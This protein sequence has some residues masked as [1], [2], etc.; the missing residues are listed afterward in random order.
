ME[1]MTG[2]ADYAA[3]KKELDTELQKTA[4]GFVK[5]GYLLK[6]ARDTDILRE[7][8]YGN[9]NDFA[10]AEYGIDNTMVSKWIRINDRFSESGYSD[11][12]KEQYR[13]FG[14]A[15]LAI[16][17]QL[18]DLLNEELTPDYSKSEIQAIKNEVD[19]ERKITDMEVL[20][21]NGTD[22]NGSQNGM[23]DFTLFEKIL[24][25]ICRDMPHV[26]KELNRALM[27]LHTEP[28]AVKQPGRFHEIMAPAGDAVYSIRVQG[29]GKFMLFVKEENISVINIRSGEKEMHTFTELVEFVKKISVPGMA[30]EQ[31][32][33]AVYGEPFPE[34]E[35]KEIAPVQPEPPKGKKKRVMTAGKKEEQHRPE[36]V[37]E[38][39][40][41]VSGNVQEHGREEVPQEIPGNAVETVPEEAADGTPEDA[42]EDLPE[43]AGAMENVTGQSEIVE[44]AEYGEYETESELREA[45]YDLAKNKIA[46]LIDD[47]TDYAEMPL[48]KITVIRQNAEQLLGILK[49][50]ERRK[51]Q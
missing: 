24:Y 29:H 7:S 33:E 50:L 30:A 51:G 31:S 6:V 38:V 22:R 44:D 34:E 9:V 13:G 2:Y 36:T 45:A 16:M 14:Y 1:Q 32:W 20:L 12:L 27:Q 35:K 10:K 4:E 42:L 37:P 47:W 18:P 39:T 43:A 40:A 3:Y 48:E 19:E 8:G 25:Q 23:G 5:I 41:A 21:E 49:E 28:E 46:M 26:Y 11:R 17:L 15:K